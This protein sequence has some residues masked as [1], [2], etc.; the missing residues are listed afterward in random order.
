MS[1]KIKSLEKKADYQGWTNYETWNVALWFGNDEGLYR[2]VV[3]T[4]TPYTADLAED[5]VL[6]LL[7]RGTLDFENRGKAKAYRKVNWEEIAEAFNEMAGL[8][9]EEVEE[10][11]YQR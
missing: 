8:E 1:K 10:E 6:E 9:D 4:K 7:P 5:L 3:N 11:Y 2:S